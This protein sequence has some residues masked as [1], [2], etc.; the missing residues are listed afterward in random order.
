MIEKNKKIFTGK[1]ILI[2][3]LI[4]TNIATNIKYKESIALNSKILKQTHMLA[5]NFKSCRENKI[6]RKDNEE[7]N[8]SDYGKY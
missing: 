5:I 8:F 3:V 1:N 7:L 4:L 2:L 6:I